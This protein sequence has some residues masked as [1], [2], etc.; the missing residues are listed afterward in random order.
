MLCF[1]EDGA[2]AD[3][4]CLAGL[5]LGYS[6]QHALWDWHGRC[7]VLQSVV[8]CNAHRQPQIQLQ[9]AASAVAADEL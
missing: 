7:C 9:T 8:D 1:S 5:P 4:P 2:V 6:Q 3:V